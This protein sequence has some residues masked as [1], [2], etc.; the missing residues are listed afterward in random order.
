[1][2]SRLCN[3]STIRPLFYLTANII[4]TK[5]IIHIERRVDLSLFIISIICLW[6]L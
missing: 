3:R 6:L 5:K 1:M 4:V 2:D